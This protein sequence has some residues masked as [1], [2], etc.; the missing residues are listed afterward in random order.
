VCI[1]CAQLWCTTAQSWSNNLSSHPPDN[2]HSSDVVCWMGGGRTILVVVTRERRYGP[3]WLRVDD[4]GHPTSA[5]F[6][7]ET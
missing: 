3:R 2:H 4:R 1:W 5:C 6:C 7:Y